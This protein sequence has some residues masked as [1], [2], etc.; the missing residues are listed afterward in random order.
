MLLTLQLEINYTKEEILN[1]YLNQIYFGHGGLWPRKG[2]RR[3]F[4][5]IGPGGLTPG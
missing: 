5:Q 3:L 2:L 1:M 4:W